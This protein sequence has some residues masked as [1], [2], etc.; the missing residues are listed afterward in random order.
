M[1]NVKKTKIMV[2][3]STDPCQEIVFDG[4]IIERV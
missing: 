1:V 2:F 4:D 3:N